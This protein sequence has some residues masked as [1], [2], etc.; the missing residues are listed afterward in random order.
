MCQTMLWL[1]QF[2][3]CLDCFERDFEELGEESAVL[4]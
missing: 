4:V 3:L 1:V 2:I